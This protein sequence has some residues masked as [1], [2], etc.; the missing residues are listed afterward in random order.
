[1]KE[2]SF[3]FGFFFHKDRFIIMTTA[4]SSFFHQN[5]NAKPQPSILFL[6]FNRNPSPSQSRHYVHAIFGKTPIFGRSCVR[7]TGFTLVE[8][9]AV[10]TIIGVLA[11]LTLGAAGAVRRHSATS[12]AKSQIAALQAA[13]D[14]YFSENNQY[15]TGTSMPN[16]ASDFNPNSGTYQQGGRV[17][18]TELFG[19][20][21]YNRAPATKRY[22]EPKTSMVN[23]T[24]SP[25]TYFIDPWGYAFGY[26]CSQ[27]S[28]G[29][30]NPPLIWST[31]GQTTGAGNTNK[32][33]AS[34]P[35]M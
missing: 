15:P 8:L 28:D 22:F 27:N 18:F 20:N 16:P 5:K 35:K 26:N 6:S 23:S 31:A 4:P 12:Q 24:N 14:R 19:T 33:V 1:M 11:G 9:L 25:T 32:W 7:A 30:W 29:T 21:Q 13:C 3:R 10:I 34:W 2:L 17:L